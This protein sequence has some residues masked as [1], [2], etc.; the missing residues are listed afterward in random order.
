MGIIS[1]WSPCLIAAYVPSGGLEPP[2]LP[3]ETACSIIELRGQINGKTT[4]KQQSEDCFLARIK[5]FSYKTSLCYHN[6]RIWA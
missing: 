3:V 5:L 1:V 4:K 6:T 2:T